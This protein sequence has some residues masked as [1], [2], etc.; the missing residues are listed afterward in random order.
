[1]QSCQCRNTGSHIAVC[2]R[3]PQTLPGRTVQQHTASDAFLPFAAPEGD[4]DAAQPQA[5]I[6][7]AD[8]DDAFSKDA[9]AQQLEDTELI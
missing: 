1:M 9:Y 5:A 3:M 7:D 4:W 2:M 8:P 6:G